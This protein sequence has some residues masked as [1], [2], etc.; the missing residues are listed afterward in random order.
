[1]NLGVDR[2]LLA[3]QGPVLRAKHPPRL[4][5]TYERNGEEHSEGI[6]LA[7]RAQQ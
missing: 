2:D 1:V 3:F 7:E 5:F 6:A 4:G